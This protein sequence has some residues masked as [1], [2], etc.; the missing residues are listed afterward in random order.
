M[1]SA[2]KT[3]KYYYVN[4]HILLF[5]ADAARLQ[6]EG[7]EHAKTI[8]DVVK[9]ID[10]NAPENCQL[11]MV[12]SKSEL[13]KEASE[14]ERVVVKALGELKHEAITVRYSGATG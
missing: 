1:S 4:A 3:W 9:E 12:F 14:G 2:V 10:E 6:R 5:L 7:G 8:V 11:I 13:V